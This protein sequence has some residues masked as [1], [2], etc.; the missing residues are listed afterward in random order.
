MRSPFFFSQEKGDAIRLPSVAEKGAKRA[1]DESSQAAR[2]P[3]LWRV[4]NNRNSG[5]IFEVPTELSML[6]F[7]FVGCRSVIAAYSEAIDS[8]S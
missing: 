2:V 1:V 6:E 5:E 7:C 8:W 4:R 3:V